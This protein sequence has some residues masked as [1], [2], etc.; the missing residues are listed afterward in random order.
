M[1]SPRTNRITLNLD[2]VEFASFPQR[3]GARICDSFIVAGIFVA[4]V[5]SLGKHF[6]I[7]PNNL[8]PSLGIG[9][10]FYYLPLFAFAYEVPLMSSRGLTIGKRIFGLCVVRT[11]GLIGIGLDRALIRFA[12]PQFIGIVPLIGVFFQMAAQV[13]YLFDPNRQNVA[14]KAA[15][16]FVIRIPSPDQIADDHLTLEEHYDDDSTPKHI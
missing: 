5:Y 9:N 2:K 12:V 13:W 14:D 3:I 7:D 16:T 6:V 1:P 8:D 15:R 4:F 11:D 10:L